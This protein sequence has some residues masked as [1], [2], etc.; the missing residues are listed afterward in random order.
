MSS[1]ASPEVEAP[2]PSSLW[3]FSLALDRAD[4]AGCDALAA[5]PYDEAMDVTRRA[6]DAAVPAALDEAGGGVAAAQSRLFYGPGLRPVGG[7]G[8]PAVVPVAN[9][10]VPATPDGAARLAD[11]LLRRLTLREVIYYRRAS[12]K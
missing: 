9:L 10:H 12:Q 1:L 2:A 3:F 5:L 4:G 8:K 7:A 6:F 11:A